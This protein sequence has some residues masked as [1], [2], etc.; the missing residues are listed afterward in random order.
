V[1]PQI[2]VYDAP[3]GGNKV[4]WV[5]GDQTN[6]PG[7]LGPGGQDWD[8]YCRD[9][10]PPPPPAGGCTPGYWKQSQ[11]YPSYVGTGVTPSTS[12]ESI[13]GDV[14]KVD[15]MSFVD[16]LGLNGGGV[17]ALMRHAAAAYLNAGKLQFALTQAQVVVLFKEAVSGQRDV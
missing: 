15:D 4:M 9:R 10:T 5:G 14:P 17:S 1:S 6:A 13:F 12:F 3:T 8:V 7:T 2:E 11:H 16:A